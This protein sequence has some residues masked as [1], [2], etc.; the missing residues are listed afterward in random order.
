M[1][2]ATYST[3]EVKFGGVLGILDLEDR[4][5][6]M[7]EMDVG[8]MRWAC[9]S[10]DESHK[11]SKILG[12]VMV[13]GEFPVTDAWQPAM[14]RRVDLDVAIDVVCLSL[15]WHKPLNEQEHPLKD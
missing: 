8:R 9:E 10:L 14:L 11:F 6:G 7:S 1:S 3:D 5:K 13:R 15:Y 4:A 12:D 2:G